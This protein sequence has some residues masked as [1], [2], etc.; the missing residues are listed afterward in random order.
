[1]YLGQA[2]AGYGIVYNTRYIAAHKIPAPVEWKDL[3]SPQWFGHVG[4][5]S[6]ARSGTMHLTVETILQ[7]EGWDEGWSTLLRMSG[8]SSA[9]T[10]RSFGVPAGAQMAYQVDTT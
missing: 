7:G 4:I 10:E 9:V 3:L 2:L 6:P 8:N 1:M 5:T